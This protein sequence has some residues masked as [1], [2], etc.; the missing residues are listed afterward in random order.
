MKMKRPEE[1]LGNQGRKSKGFRGKN[2]GEPW[3]KMKRNPGKRKI[4][5]EIRGR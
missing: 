5:K 4:D 2:K 1:T 3:K